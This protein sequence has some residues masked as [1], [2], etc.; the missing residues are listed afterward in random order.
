[1]SKA[2]TFLLFPYALVVAM[3]LSVIV[4][5]ALSLLGAVYPAI[6]AARMKPAVA[7]RYEE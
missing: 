2:V 7:L 3:L 6:L 5:T 4:S 1:L